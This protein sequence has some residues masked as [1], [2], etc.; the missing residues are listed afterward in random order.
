MKTKRKAI[1]WNI[2]GSSIKDNFI[3][4]IT[5]DNGKTS[6]TGRLPFIIKYINL[7]QKK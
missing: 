6:I 1:D 2:T 7:I 4:N 3:L 5:Y